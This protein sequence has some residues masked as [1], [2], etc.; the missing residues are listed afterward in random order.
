[1]QVGQVRAVIFDVDGTLMDT[2][3]H[4]A[5]AWARALLAVGRPTPRSVIHRQIGKGADQFLPEFVTDAARAHEADRRHGEEYAGIV[6]TAAPLPGAKDILKRLPEQGIGVWL[7][8]SA[9]PQELE[10]TLAA[11]EAEESIAGIVSSGD[12]E[13]SKPAPDIFALALEKTGLEPSDVVIVGDTIWDV[14]AA[15]RCGLRTVAVLTG[16]AFSRAELTEAGA[17]AVYDDCAALIEAGFP[18]NL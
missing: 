5:E 14:I 2:N 16:G 11:L 8:T 9:Q 6:Q 13:D 4:H 7:A 15:N 3:Y 1:M 12:V 17:I 18:D 10:T